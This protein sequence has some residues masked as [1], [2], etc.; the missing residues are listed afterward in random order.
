M[1]NFIVKKKSKHKTKQKK[2]PQTGGL[3]V[4]ANECNLNHIGD[5]KECERHVFI[6]HLMARVHFCR[7]LEVTEMQVSEA[8]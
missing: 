8:N 3:Y 2:S 5:Y 4:Y 7:H 1:S 6:F